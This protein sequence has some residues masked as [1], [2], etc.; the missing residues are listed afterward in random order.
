MLND[1]LPEFNSQTLKF[2]NSYLPEFSTTMLGNISF[3]CKYYN[4]YSPF[5]HTSNGANK[6]ASTN[7]QTPLIFKYSNSETT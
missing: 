5:F 3:Q 7:A 2:L 6:V 4:T 1:Y